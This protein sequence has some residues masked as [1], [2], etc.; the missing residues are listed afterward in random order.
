VVELLEDGLPPQ[1]AAERGIHL[2]AE[3]V[4]GGRGGVIV[5]TPNGEV[6]LAW[7]T[8]RMAYAYI[9]SHGAAQA[10]V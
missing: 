2:L 7:N 6:G 5:L 9:T 10:G 8:S 1:V 3:L 4:A